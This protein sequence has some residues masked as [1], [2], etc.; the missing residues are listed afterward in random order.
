M[1]EKAAVYDL[2]EV[3]ADEK[4]PRPVPSSDARRAPNRHR[5]APERT[6]IDAG[7]MR[8]QGAWSVSFSVFIPGSGHILR[9]DLSLGMFYLASMGFLGALCWAILGTLDRLGATFTLLNLPSAIGPWA[10]CAI[11]ACFTAAYVANVCSAA[12][13]RTE[14]DRYGAPPPFISGIASAI[15]PGWGQALA[16]HRLSAALFLSG[17]WLVGG[18]WLLVSPPVQAML[19]SQGLYLPRALELL[20]SP[21]VRWALPAILWILAVYGAVFRVTL[22]R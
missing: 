13:G 18:A 5:T 7:R 20:A 19:D 14:L 4:R 9:G 16:G 10:L 21:V 2:G 1:S 17:C 12:P 22:R 15:V 6:A 11:F 8:V 3:S